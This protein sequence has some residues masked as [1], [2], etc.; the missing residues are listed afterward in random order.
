LGRDQ[1]AAY[2]TE[3]RRRKKNDFIDGV[4]KIISRKSCRFIR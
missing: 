2:Q 4:H 1:R 3:Q